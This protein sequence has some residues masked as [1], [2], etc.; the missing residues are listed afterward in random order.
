MNTASKAVSL[1]GT[2]GIRI[3]SCDMAVPHFRVWERPVSSCD[4]TNHRNHPR[5]STCDLTKPG[6]LAAES[7]PRL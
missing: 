3:C 6:W 7:V 5:D 4:T 2:S 1:V